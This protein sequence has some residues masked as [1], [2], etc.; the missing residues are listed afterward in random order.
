MKYLKLIAIFIAC[1]F[2]SFDRTLDALAEDYI[3]LHKDLAIIEM[4]RTGVPASI[5]LAQALHETDFGRSRLA[6]EANNHFGIKC[7][8]YW[9]GQIF[10]HKDD[11]YDKAGK[12][13]E[14]CFRRY[15]SNLE[16]YVDHSN[17]LTGSERYAPLFKL[18]RIDYKA[19]ANGLKKCGYAT[20]PSYADKLIRKIER[21]N[22]SQYDFYECPLNE[23]RAKNLVQSKDQ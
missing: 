19:W 2:L 5:T 15:N 4:H 12:L 21:Y 16:S 9:Q 22:L 14:S 20:D 23:A 10:Y 1:G 11:D 3:T 7:K 17:F 18:S 8:S 6:R 13:I